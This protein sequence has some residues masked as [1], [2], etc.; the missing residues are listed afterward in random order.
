M[1]GDNERSTSSFWIKISDRE[2]ATYAAKMSGMPIFLF[3]IAAVASTLS[4]FAQSQGRLYLIAIGAI[5]LFCIT[6]GLR[7]RKGRFGLIIFV[8][9]LYL[10]MLGI[11]AVGYMGYMIQSYRSYPDVITSLFRLAE[12]IVPSLLGIFALAGL[13]GWWWLRRNPA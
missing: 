2:S 8:I 1:V 13:R 11:T 12:M 10:I 9:P 3:G 5:G 4:D 7:I 6:S